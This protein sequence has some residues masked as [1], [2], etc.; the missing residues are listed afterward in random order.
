MIYRY[1]K[2]WFSVMNENIFGI[3]IG[4]GHGKDHD[5]GQFDGERL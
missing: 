2:R 1:I 4:K 5:Y 3:F